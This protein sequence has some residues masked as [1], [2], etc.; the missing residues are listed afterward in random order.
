MT[1][2]ERTEQAEVF[3]ASIE[4][5]LRLAEEDE[6]L[7]QTRREEEVEIQAVG[8]ALAPTDQGPARLLEMAVQQDLDIDKLERL[9]AMKER[10]DAQKAK[11]AFYA[12]L[13]NFQKIVPVLEKRNVVDFKGKSGGEVRYAYASLSDIKAQIQEGLS[14]CGL[15]YRW[16]FADN[17]GNI[18]VTCIVTH[19]LGH[20]E[21]TTMTAPADSSGSK[22]PV[23]ERASTITYLQRYT[24]IGALGLTTAN[25]DD[26]GRK[27]QAGSPTPEESMKN[28]PPVPE[29]TETKAPFPETPGKADFEK[30]QQ[31]YGYLCEITGIDPDES[32]LKLSGD[33]K[34]KLSDELV[35]LTEFESEGKIKSETS[36]RKLKGK[37]LNTALGKAK[38]K[39]GTAKD[40][41]LHLLDCPALSQEYAD[42][43]RKEADDKRHKEQ[44]YKD[45]IAIVK[46]LIADAEKEKE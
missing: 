32:P 23:Q 25:Q 43:Y 45:Q 28:L 15:S 39:L 24:L 31:L 42:E 17:T 21:K 37:W 1:E 34:K 33:D 30:Q 8:L 9:V 3:D 6:A 38:A 41:L 2:Q 46:G 18:D 19:I 29:G 14:D 35:A 44:W 11:E 22:N 4:G 13:V 27:G 26:D 7:E 10:W 5:K 20:S 12:A 36:L 40:E 16:E